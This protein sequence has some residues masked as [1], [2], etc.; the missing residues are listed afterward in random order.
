[1]FGKKSKKN[2]DKKTRRFAN[3]YEQLPK[4]TFLGGG[5]IESSPVQREHTRMMVSKQERVERI[6]LVA[7]KLKD[8]YKK[9]PEAELFV[10]Y[11]RATD[12]IFARA[13]S[14]RWSIERTEREMIEGEIY[15]MSLHTGFEEDVFTQVYDEFMSMNQG[16]QRVQVVAKKLQD[17]YRGKYDEKVVDFISYMR[18]YL[19][20]FTQS[21]ETN[22]SLDATKEE[23]I[24]ARMQVVSASG[25]PPIHLLETVYSE[26]V[27]RLSE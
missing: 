18:D 27:L 20:I 2:D 11:L 22:L 21:M 7:S 6:E 17:K 10:E 14:E 12:Q 25:T 26:F 23:I 13:E 9:I 1:M 8:R 15:L 3:P 24:H 19:L 16:A 5:E 4:R